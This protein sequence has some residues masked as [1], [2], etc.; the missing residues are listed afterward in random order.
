MFDFILS[1][2]W[3]Y[4]LYLV[5]RFLF[6]CGYFVYRHYIRKPN[7]VSQ[8]YGENT[9]ALITG[10]TD[11]IGKGI[12][13][14]FAK[15][16]FNIILVSRSQEKLN[17]VQ[18][19]IQKLTD[20]KIQ[21]KTVAF[22]FTQK[23]LVQDYEEAFSFVRD[24]D[25][26]VLINNVGW[27]STKRFNF[28][29]GK[30][31]QDHININVV[32][33]IILTN[34]FLNQL[35]GRSGLKSLIVNV[36]SFASTCQGAKFTIYNGVKACSVAHSKLVHYENKT[37]L[38]CMVVRPMFV[39]T[40]LTK[41]LNKKE[42]DLNTISVETLTESLSKQYGHD[43]DTF[44]AARHEWQARLTLCIPNFIAKFKQFTLN[45]SYDY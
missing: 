18:D 7:D 35:T 12:A 31:I 30:V 17:N 36:A 24:L 20:Y 26:S 13:I 19:E 25:L 32:P 5:L 33:Q 11:G 23:F 1:I 37:N 16:G 10:A 38:D 41:P 3:Y 40:P 29:E 6:E 2:F 39:E 34:M 45:H 9:W 42:G 27:T 43:F 28:Y 4:T 8:R 14:D 21:I 15:K 22:D 44:G